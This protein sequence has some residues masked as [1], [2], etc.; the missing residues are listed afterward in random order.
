MEAVA[1]KHTLRS[2]TDPVILALSK[3]TAPEK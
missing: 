2:S 3:A 1:P